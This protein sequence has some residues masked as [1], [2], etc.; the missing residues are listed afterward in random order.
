MSY[1]YSN[2]Y[3]PFCQFYSDVIILQIM[4]IFNKRIVPGKSLKAI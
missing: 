3:S 4:S 1:S 2:D